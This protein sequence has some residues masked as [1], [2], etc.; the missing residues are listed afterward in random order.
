MHLATTAAAASGKGPKAGAAAG[1]AAKTGGKGA[2]AGVLD[3]EGALRLIQAVMSGRWV[4][5]V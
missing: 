5:S 3:E 4:Y 1:A 2:A